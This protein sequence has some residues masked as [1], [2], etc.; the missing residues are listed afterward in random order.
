MEGTLYP[1]LS[2]LKTDGV[3]S[4]VWV[5]SANGPPRKYYRITETGKDLLKL[6]DIHWKELSTAINSIT[7]H[8]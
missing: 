6:M 4:Y 8:S 3:L 1:L 5:E 2:R 7:K